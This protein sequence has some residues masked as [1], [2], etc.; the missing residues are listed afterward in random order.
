M[1]GQLQADGQADVVVNAAIIGDLPFEADGRSWRLAF[2]FNALCR[3]E[4]WVDNQA[5][6]EALLK[7]EPP[8]MSAV[9][10][11][12]LAGLGDAHPDLTQEDAGRLID[13]LGPARAASLIYQALVLAFPPAKK[14]DGARPRKATR[15][16]A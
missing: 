7:G 14:G 9:R 16:K 5:D 10:S 12:M 3:M 8:S 1:L 13:H 15:A 4:Q 6:I 11:A 2:S